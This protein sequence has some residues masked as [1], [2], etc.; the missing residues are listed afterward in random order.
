MPKADFVEL[1]AVRGNCGTPDT[2]RRCRIFVTRPPWTW[3]EVGL[4]A[5]WNQVREWM[6]RI[7]GVRQ[8]VIADVHGG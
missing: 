6:R 3:I 7:D 5:S 4:L 8:A 1:L 2:A